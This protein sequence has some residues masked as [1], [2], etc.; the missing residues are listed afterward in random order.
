MSEQ[1]PPVKVAEALPIKIASYP[2]AAIRLV[3]SI[4][5]L[6]G[7]HLYIREDAPREL[8]MYKGER[9][10]Y[11]LRDKELRIIVEGR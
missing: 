2:V 8:L 9:L 1:P 10:I 5:R 6:V 3:N 7:D 11:N 4:L